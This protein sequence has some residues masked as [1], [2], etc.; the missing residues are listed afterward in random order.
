[1]DLLDVES[2]LRSH[3]AS[4]PVP[5]APGDLAERTRTRHRRQRRQQAAVAG[6]VLAVVA[7]FGSVPALRA[8]LPAVGTAEDAAAPTADD[9]PP[10]YDV[11]TR[12]SLAGDT[13]WLDGV[14]ALPWATGERVP[15]TD[16]PADS[17]RVAYAADV[18]GVRIALVLAKEGTRVSGAWFTGAPGAAPAEM[19]QAAGARRVPGNERPVLVDAPDPGRAP[20]LVVVTRPGDEDVWLS[21]GR[22]VEADGDEEQVPWT[23]LDVRDGVALGRLGTVSGGVPSAQVQVFRNGQLAQQPVVQ[24]S[25]RAAALASRPVV[26]ADP[27]GLRGGFPEAELQSLVQQ[28]AGY[29]DLSPEQLGPTLLATGTVGADPVALVGFTHPSGATSVWSARVVTGDP[30]RSPSPYSTSSTSAASNGPAGIALADR[31]LAVTTDGGL[32]VSGPADGVAA[33]VLERD[34]TSL[35]TLALVAGVGAGALPAGSP[36]E[37]RVTDAA[38]RV[39]VEAPVTP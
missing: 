35:G 4:R 7:V 18:D 6:A 13:D 5:R 19:T 26:V 21:A 28:A 39:L 30:G 2:E 37:V 17:R 20:V 12:G 22:V 24:L 31:V 38:G 23:R 15:D 36:A 29:Y 16:P 14:A 34:G 9:A 25:D 8:V 27:R 10:L 32:V 33:E 1:M 11:P 3:L